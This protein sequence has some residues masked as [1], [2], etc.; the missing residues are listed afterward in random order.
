[1]TLREKQALFCECIGEL[2]ARAY[3]QGYEFTL[4][5]AYR[6]DR[7]GHML[8]SL[9]YERLA[10]DLNLFVKGKWKDRDCP[11]WQELGAYWK[12]LHPLAAWGGDFMPPLKKDYNH[13]SFIHDGK[14]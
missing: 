2:I 9:H 12:N 7:K 5:E 4:G 6:G 1:M 3:A 8:G 10:I 11:E 14:A 13:F